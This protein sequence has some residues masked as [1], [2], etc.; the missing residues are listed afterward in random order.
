MW[1]KGKQVK[2]NFEQA[3]QER[4]A[5]FMKCINLACDTTDKISKSLDKNQSEHG[6]LGLTL[7]EAPLEGINYN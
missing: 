6:F 2:M 1:W 4:F 3:K 7:E 5:F